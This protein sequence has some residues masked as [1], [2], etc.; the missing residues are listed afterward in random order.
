M[1]HPVSASL[2][3]VVIV[4]A[5][6]NGA[7][8]LQAQL[9]SYRSQTLR[10]SLL[11][12]GDDGSTDATP[13]I[14]EAFAASDPGFEVRLLRG[15]RRGAARNF[16]ALLRE[17]PPEA[18][19]LALSDQ[20]DVWLPDRLAQGVRGLAALPAGRIGL[21]GGRTYVCDATLTRRRLSAL[22][23]KRLGF[24]HALVQ[25]FAG[26]NTMLLNR[27]AI[28][29]V[30]AAVPEVGRIVVHDWWLY[31][32]VSGAGGA[33]IFEQ[34]PLVLYRQ[35]PENQIGANSG[36]RAKLRRMGMMIRGD[37][38]RWNTINLRAMRASAHRL[39][40]E[41]RDLLDGFARLQRSGLL[42]RLVLLR[43]LGLYRRGLEGT[44]S[45]WLAALMGR[46]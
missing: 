42:S 3:R 20:D 25:N 27:P 13:A 35:H 9:D 33:V 29:L 46:I 37:F 28:A 12:V 15:P 6:R 32:I 31:Q 41:H 19:Y 16:L 4:L 36:W 2:P 26:G 7:A 44:L 24:R 8:N 43:Q 45:L 14:L 10:P 21:L 22:P 30:Q 40:P 1:S 5:T 38:R 17:V 11:I 34:T 18:D 39:T 23:C